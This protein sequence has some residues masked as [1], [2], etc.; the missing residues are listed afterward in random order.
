MD[1]KKPNP[2]QKVGIFLII[3]GLFLG[4]VMLDV[5]NLGSIREYF[6]WPMLLIFI[7]VVS[8][9]NSNAAAGIILI[10][11]GGYF[12]LPRIDYELPL[13]YEKLYWPT[14]IILA[15]LVF[16]VSGIIRRHRRI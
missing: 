1:D 3:L 15:G 5:L 13:I 16:I 14:A 10:A 2:G 7:G 11:V 4:S 8:F 9:F 6:V 12:F